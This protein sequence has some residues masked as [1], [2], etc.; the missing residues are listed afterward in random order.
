MI[1]RQRTECCRQYGTVLIGQLLRMQL[2]GKPQRS[3]RFEHAACLRRRET[4]R[5]AERVDGVH[6]PLAMQHRHPLAHRCDV[7]VRTALV[8]GGQRV[9]AKEGGTY[10]HGE[11]APDGACHS[12]RAGFGLE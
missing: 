9:G 4:D 10:I 8:L 3:R 1:T 2:H 11:R 12:Q 6:Q 7:V 5:F